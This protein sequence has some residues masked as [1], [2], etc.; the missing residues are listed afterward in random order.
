MRDLKSLGRN[1]VR[2]QISKRALF[3]LHINYLSER[4]KRVWTLEC[5]SKSY[6]LTAVS[7]YVPLT[8][9]FKGRDAKQPKAYLEGIG[10]IKI[11]GRRAVIV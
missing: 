8:T 5:K 9:V 10:I 2:V 4:Y 1:T 11:R 3:K 6:I 7:I